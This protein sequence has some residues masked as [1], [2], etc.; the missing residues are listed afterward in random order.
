MLS[1]FVIPVPKIARRYYKPEPPKYYTNDPQ[2]G[3]YPNL[4]FES[5]FKRSPYGWWDEQ[6][7]RN[8]GESF[9]EQEDAINV[10]AFDI[11]DCHIPT[12]L[13]QMATF[14]LG[15]GVLAIIITVTVPERPA[16]PKT[17][18]YDNLRVELGG[19]PDDVNDRGLSFPP[20]RM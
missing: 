18:P 4:P 9:H 16:V 2:I 8:F 7:R 1:R 14:F 17:Y 13:K 20:P 5:K 10:W 11:Y 12:A 15:V 6:E 19:D 3:D